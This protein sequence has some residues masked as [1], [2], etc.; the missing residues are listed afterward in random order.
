MTRGML[1][2]MKCIIQSTASEADTVQ[3][4]LVTRNE[5]EWFSLCVEDNECSVVSYKPI[6]GSYK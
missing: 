5:L 3:A 2:K 1:C 6:A 4:P